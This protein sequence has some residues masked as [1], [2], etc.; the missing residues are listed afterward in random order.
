MPAQ[1]PEPHAGLY[2]LAH[3]WEQYTVPLL[4][5]STSIVLI[6]ISIFLIVKSVQNETPIQFSHSENSLGISTQ[7]GEFAKSSTIITIDVEG[8]V[9]LPGVYQLPTGSRVEDAFRVAG[10]LSEEADVAYIARFLNRAG[11]LG[12]GMKVYV[13]T[14]E[15]AMTSYINNT[16]GN[17]RLNETS[18]NNSPLL[19]RPEGPS[20]NGPVSI[21][22]ASQSELESLPGVG[23]VTAQK[24]MANRPYMSLE[25]LIAKKAMGQALFDKIKEQLTL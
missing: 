1:D 4:L 11:R 17:L 10:G 3:F 18:H 22:T 14:R 25:D 15:E 5:G 12:D 9:V 2:A 23:P 19:Q 13:P 7:S 20:Q 6:A 16:K 8:A 21:N 24:I